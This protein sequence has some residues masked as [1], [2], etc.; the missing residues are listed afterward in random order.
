[1]LEATEA[2][3]EDEH[4]EEW[5]NIF[6]QEDEKTV[7]L[8]LA[9]VE[10]EE[11]DIMSFVDLWQQIETLERRVEVQNMHI[12]Q[13][14][15][16]PDGGGFQSEE[17]LE[18]AGDTP[19]G[20]MAEVELPP[21]EAEQQFSD[22]TAREEFAA[23]WQIKA[24]EDEEDSIG[25]HD[26]LPICKEKLQQSTLHEQ[27]QP[28]QQLDEVIKA[29]RKLMI[30]SIEVVSEGKIRIRETVATE[31]QKQQQQQRDGAGRQLQRVFWDP[32]GFQ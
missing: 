15:L 27:S 8:K 12:Q 3:E 28:L 26:D 31:Q 17:Q 32:G 29:I 6:S 1:M 4:S 18:R 23:R 10:E 16:E 7:A 22:R 20:E 5:L 19:A 9:E 21:G 24:I 11:V 2:E 25:D 30:Q 13:M 14:R